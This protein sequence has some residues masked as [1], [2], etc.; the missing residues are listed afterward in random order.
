LCPVNSHEL[1]DGSEYYSLNTEGDS[2]EIIL[3]DEFSK[4]VGDYPFTVNAIAEGG[5]STKAD[6]IMTVYDSTIDAVREPTETILTD[7]GLYLRFSILVTRA[8]QKLR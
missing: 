5:A 2:F 7:D 6:F 4:T 3:K 1:V 8:T